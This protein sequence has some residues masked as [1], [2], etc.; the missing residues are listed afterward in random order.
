MHNW[1]HR[2][3]VIWQNKYIASLYVNLNMYSPIDEMVEIFD[4]DGLDKVSISR[5]KVR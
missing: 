1:N 3:T 5:P 2:F 4:Q